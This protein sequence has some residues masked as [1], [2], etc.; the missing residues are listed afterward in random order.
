MKI[1]IY[2]SFILCYTLSHGQ[3]GKDPI[4][5]LENI[6]KKLIS[7]G[8]Y[9]GFNTYNFNFDY[10]TLVAKDI[11]VES[12]TGFNV[13]LVGDVRLSE[14]FNIR[15]EPGLS[16]NNRILIFR[17]LKGEINQVREVPSTYLHFPLLLKTSTRRTGN[18]KPFILSGI[19]TA[20]NLSSNHD[21]TEDNSSGKFRMTRL[22]NYYE[23]GFGVDLFFEYFKFTPSIRGV[24]SLGDE[25][26]R[27]NDP[28]SP[29]TGSISKMS[30]KAVFIN[31]TF[32]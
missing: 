1:F 12:S 17:E 23:L 7:W 2:I 21:A 27:D 28:N 32:Q 25:L 6:D 18:V 4:T 14:F 22:T 31:F 15:F 11:K 24:F 13:G 29:W 5:N 9:L 19:S 8:Y 10:N 26:V 16:S 3:F 20:I 30:S